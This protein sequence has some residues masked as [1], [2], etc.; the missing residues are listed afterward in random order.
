M[1]TLRKIIQRDGEITIREADLGGLLGATVFASTPTAVVLA[2]ELTPDEWRSTLAH[3]LMHVLRGPVPRHLAAAEEEAVQHAT[4]AMLVPGASALA[5]LDHA[6]STKEI[7]QLAARHL[8][9]QDT[10]ETALNPPTIPI[11]IPLPRSE[12]A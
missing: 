11:R 9:D 1:S 3:E 10:M 8:V 12:Q 7:Q 2:P 5:Q 6:W 4:A